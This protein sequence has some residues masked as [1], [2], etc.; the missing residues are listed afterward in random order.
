MFK[1]HQM[2]PGTAVAQ[3]PIIIVPSIT[4]LVLKA[5][6]ILKLLHNQSHQQITALIH[7]IVPQTIPIRLLLK[8]R[9]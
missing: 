3:H 4:A 5:H 9:V 2:T 6:P 7:Q 1:I 8:V